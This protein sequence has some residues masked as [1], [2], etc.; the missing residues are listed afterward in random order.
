MTAPSVPPTDRPRRP[1]RRWWIPVA[2]AGVALL[3]G[4]LLAEVA[5]RLAGLDYRSPYV[6]DEHSGTGL[7]PGFRYT[8]IQEGRATIQINRAGFRDREHSLEK[9]AGSFRI[10]VLGDSF[11]EALQVDQSR[12]FWSVLE[13]ELQACPG[14]R[15]QTVEVL[16]FGI[17]GFGTAQ[18][19]ELLRH[20]VWEYAPD[21]V[22]LAF[23]PA[24]DVRNN[25]RT[26]ETDRRRPFYH[27]EGN[28]LELDR[29]FLTDP[30]VVRQRTSPSIWIKDLLRRN[31]LLL[32]LVYHVRHRAAADPSA[33]RGT[34]IG[35]D[36]RVF[37]PPQ[38]RAWREA[39]QIT[40]GI[41]QRMADEVRQHGARLAVAV[42]N[43]AVQVAPDPV[44]TQTLARQLGVEDLDE[45]DR[46]LAQFG[47][48]AGVPVILLTPPMR[49]LARREKIH[50]H[51]F[52]NT[53]PGTG[54]WN[55][56]GHQTAGEIL[57]RELC[58]LLSP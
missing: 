35:L 3:F 24:N 4:L 10:A 45:P 7:L 2:T 28:R 38:D 14:F 16:N 22:L 26:L 1:K 32:A 19:L 17:S 33:A 25:S 41:L 46:R 39:W 13:R 6:F 27:F 48:D 49:E 57:A 54:H 37:A 43:N 51:G 47:R 40:D 8:Q 56:R 34:E 23:L 11:A 12:T 5:L 31:S 30:G 50:F 44:D 18:E 29:S 58:S 20:R 42:L 53:A 55:E 52:P 36:E 9:P 15:E 21:L